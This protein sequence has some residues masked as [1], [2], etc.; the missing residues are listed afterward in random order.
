[1]IDPAAEGPIVERA[2]P[3]RRRAALQ[4]SISADPATPITSPGRR[5]R[6]CQ[7]SRRGP[8]PRRASP[9]ANPITTLLSQ[10]S[11]PTTQIRYS[12]SR[13]D[14]TCGATGPPRDA[15]WFSAVRLRRSS[16]ARS[17]QSHQAVRC[18]STRGR[19]AFGGMTKL[20]R[21]PRICRLAEVRT[22]SAPTTVFAG[23][24]PDVYDSINGP[25]SVRRREQC[26][27]CSNHC[28]IDKASPRCCQEGDVATSGGVDSLTKGP[29]FPPGGA[30]DSRKTRRVSRVRTSY[31]LESPV[32][33]AN[34]RVAAAVPSSST[35]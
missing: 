35:G 3:K 22:P 33:R 10:T 18:S 34:K 20:T 2:M 8:C 13:R 24:V 27:R 29:A 16:F 11:E 26:N 1:M 7:A 17:G 23:A 9:T 21:P 25:A 12:G 5:G 31:G 4:T 15:V 19:R 28:S 32:I 6:G 14:G 30:V